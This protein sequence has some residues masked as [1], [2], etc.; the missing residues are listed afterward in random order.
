VEDAIA[1]AEKGA[2]AVHL[3][4]PPVPLWS[5][6]GNVPVVV[7]DWGHSLIHAAQKHRGQEPRF[8]AQ[9]PLDPAAPLELRRADG[10]YSPVELAVLRG[11][12]TPA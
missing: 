2:D 3:T 10:V 9:P 1:T 7:F 5:E 4:G 8:M 11:L 12:G 6:R